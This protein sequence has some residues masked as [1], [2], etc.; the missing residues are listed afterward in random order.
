[1]RYDRIRGLTAGLL[2]PATLFTAAGADAQQPGGWSGH[3]TLYGWLP[4]ING[5]QDGPDGRPIVD[6]DTSNVL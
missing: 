6:L 1:M 2:L 5:V 3:A 4:V